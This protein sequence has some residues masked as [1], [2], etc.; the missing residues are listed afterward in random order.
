MVFDGTKIGFS[1][2]DDCA[3]KTDQAHS[4][5]TIG[6]VKFGNPIQVFQLLAVKHNK[7]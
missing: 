6:A 5:S 1:G 4:V 2:T 3:D 7:V